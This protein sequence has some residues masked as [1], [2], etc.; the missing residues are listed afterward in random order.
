LLIHDG[1]LL[2]KDRSIAKFNTEETVADELGIADWV[3]VIFDV[4]TD[5]LDHHD[6]EDYFDQS[7]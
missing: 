5:F 7:E 3:V 6:V 1:E 2:I 4:G